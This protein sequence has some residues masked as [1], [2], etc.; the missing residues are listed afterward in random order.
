MKVSRKIAD[1][2]LGF[3]LFASR[4]ETWQFALQKDTGVVEPV[5]MVCYFG[6]RGL[7]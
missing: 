4:G 2:R 3:K 1:I 6:D 7:E 5:A